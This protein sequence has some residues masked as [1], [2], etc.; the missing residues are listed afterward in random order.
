M[1]HCNQF[2]FEKMNI[3]S[4]GLEELSTKEMKSCNGGNPVVVALLIIAA[5]LLLTGDTKQEEDDK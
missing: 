1:R 5:C 4:L 3:K 2:Q